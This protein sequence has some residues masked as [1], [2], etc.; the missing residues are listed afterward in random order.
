MDCSPTR[1]LCPR[2]FPG[3]NTGVGCYFLAPGNFP[4]P[5]IKST[6]L[7]SP[8]LAGDSLP[9]RHHQMRSYIHA[10]DSQVALVVK[11]LPANTSAEEL[12]VAGL[13]PGSGRV[14]GEGNGSPLQFSCL[15]NPMDK[16]AWQARVHGVTKSQTQL[17]G[18]AHIHVKCLAH[19]G[20]E[21]ILSLI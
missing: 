9:L 14:P 7:S 19:R 16:G 8:A 3:K 21:S 1:L 12:R 10:R 5:G 6:S 13:I 2:D 18:L 15:G 17:K 4:D 20:A 11:N